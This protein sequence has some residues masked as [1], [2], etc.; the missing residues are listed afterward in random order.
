MTKCFNNFCFFFATIAAA[1]FLASCFCTGCRGFCPLTPV[2]TGCC[3][4]LCLFLFTASSCTMLFLF[5]IFGAGR[6]S[7]NCPVCHIMTKCFNDVCFFFATIAAAS[8]LTSCFCTGR[9]GFFPLTPFVT[10]CFNN[11]CFFS[12]A[13]FSFTM[14]FFLSILRTGCRG[15]FPV[16][17]VMAK[18]RKNCHFFCFIL[19]CLTFFYQ[20]SIIGTGWVCTINS[21]P[22]AASGIYRHLTI[23]CFCLDSDIVVSVLFK[24]AAACPALYIFCIFCQNFIYNKTTVYTNLIKTGRLRSIFQSQ[25]ISYDGICPRLFLRSFDALQIIPGTDFQLKTGAIFSK[26]YINTA[27]STVHPFYAFKLDRSAPIICTSINNLFC[28]TIRIMCSY[29]QAF[30][31]NKISFKWHDG[32]IVRSRYNFQTIHFLFCLYDGETIVFVI[33]PSIRSNYIC[34]T[35]FQLYR[36]RVAAFRIFMAILCIQI[37]IISFRL[38]YQ[39]TYCLRICFLISA[40]ILSVFRRSEA[41][42]LTCLHRNWIRLSS[43]QFCQSIQTFYRCRQNIRIPGITVIHIFCG[44][45]RHNIQTVFKIFL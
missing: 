32:I 35:F 21:F 30:H 6:R 24:I 12:F 4:N 11:F 3:N 27:C 9:R 26:C 41:I 8:F 23:P 44:I 39:N 25:D 13:A 37:S 31:R 19:M 18:R 15:F 22:Y 28:C 14:A 40:D 45:V 1:S 2:V 10:G 33:I 17:P 36:K 20:L 29:L 43:L 42:P 5:S 7:C 34:L 16:A 38:S